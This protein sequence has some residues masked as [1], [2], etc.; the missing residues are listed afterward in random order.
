[1]SYLLQQLLRETGICSLTHERKTGA[2]IAVL[3]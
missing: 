2:P 3:F 1:M